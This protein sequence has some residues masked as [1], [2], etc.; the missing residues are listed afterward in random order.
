MVL[1]IFYIALKIN[2][3][4]PWPQVRS[5]CFSFVCSIALLSFVHSAGQIFHM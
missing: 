1:F 4:L 3:F 2:N 5:N